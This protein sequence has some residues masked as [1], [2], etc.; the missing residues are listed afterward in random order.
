M[1]TS[2]IRE[3]SERTLVPI[4]LIVALLVGVFWLSG[5]ANKADAANV[6][7]NE[8]A[9]DFKKIDERLSRIEGKLGINR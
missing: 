9:H 5:V 4:S 2:S 7:A 1:S 6:M 8:C 3:I